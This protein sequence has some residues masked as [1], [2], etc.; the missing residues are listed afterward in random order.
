[1]SGSLADHEALERALDAFLMAEANAK[2]LDLTAT[3][4]Q[5]VLRWNE[6]SVRAVLCGWSYGSSVA[7]VEFSLNRVASFQRHFGRRTPTITHMGA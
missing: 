6:L 1:M 3:D 7:C 4:D 2:A 5:S